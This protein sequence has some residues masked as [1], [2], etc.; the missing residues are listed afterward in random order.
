MTNLVGRTLDRYRIEAKLG[1]GGM[2]LVYKARDTQLD[3]LVA[4]KVLPDDRTKRA[5]SGTSA[6]S[7][8]PTSPE[9]L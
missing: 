4:I 5:V 3:R 7:V 8:G 2:G 9:T 1:Q 6:V